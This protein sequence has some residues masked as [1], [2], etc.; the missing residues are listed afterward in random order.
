MRGKVDWGGGGWI[1]TQCFLDYCA[2][3]LG[4]RDGLRRYLALVLGGGAKLDWKAVAVQLLQRKGMEFV[5]RVR[6]RTTGDCV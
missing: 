4:A 1:Y 3:Y 6:R 5:G 2:Q